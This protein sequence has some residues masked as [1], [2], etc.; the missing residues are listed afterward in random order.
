MSPS[1]WLAYTYDYIRK[2]HAERAQII[3][4]WKIMQFGKYALGVLDWRVYEDSYDD[5]KNHTGG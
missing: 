3:R 1:P 4:S 5:E 2:P